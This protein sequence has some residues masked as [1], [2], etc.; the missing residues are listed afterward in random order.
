MYQ[1]III[2]LTSLSKD[3]LVGLICDGQLAVG[4]GIEVC[5]YVPVLDW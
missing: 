2:Q 4:V 1:C 3:S 5:G